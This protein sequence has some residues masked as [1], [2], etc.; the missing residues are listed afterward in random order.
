MPIISGIGGPRQRAPHPAL[1][2]VPV[3]KETD[4]PPSG[5][6]GKPEEVAKAV[7]FLASDDVSFIN[8]FELAINGGL[9]QV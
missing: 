5:R 8:G 1:L 4:V 2:Y 6:A 3:S 9:V 7:A